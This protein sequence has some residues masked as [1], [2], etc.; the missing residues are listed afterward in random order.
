MSSWDNSVP[1]PVRSPRKPAP[2]PAPKEVK[3]AF[4]WPK[5]REK[6]RKVWDP[7]E[8]EVRDTDVLKDMTFRDAFE[9]FDCNN[10]GRIPERSGVCM[11]TCTVAVEVGRALVWRYQVIVL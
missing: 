5:I 9:S 4:C 11:A 10:T 6:T 3:K 1:P 2:V 8:R 7:D